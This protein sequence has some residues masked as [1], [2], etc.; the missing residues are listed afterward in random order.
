[1]I[2]TP[3]LPLGEAG[4][5]AKRSRLMRVGEQS[6]FAEHAKLCFSAPRPSSGSLRSPPSPRGRQGVRT[7]LPLRAKAAAANLREGQAPPLR[8]DEIMSFA[9][10]FF[11]PL[12]SRQLQ[13]LPY[14]LR[15]RQPSCQRGRGAAGDAQT[16]GLRAAVFL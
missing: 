5:G 15:T 1:M 7:A 9:P 11:H 6:R 12:P 10:L 8:Y 16:Q 3:W 4:C 2:G 13:T 14:L